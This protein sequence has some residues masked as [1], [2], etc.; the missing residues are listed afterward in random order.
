MD[1]WLEA[2]YDNRAKVPDHPSI[3]Q[4]WQRDAAA[5]RA[6]HPHLE[7]GLAYGDTPRQAM[8]LFWPDGRRDAPVALFLHGGYW[9]ALDRSWFSHLAR[10]FVGHG[11][12]LAVPSYDLCPQVTL[13][14]L[15][16]QVRDAA[17]FL[18]RRH[19]RA[20]FASGHSAGGHLAAMLLAADWTGRGLPPGAV[21]GA[22]VVSG[23]FDLAPLLA[24]RINGALGLDAGT[25]RRLSPVFLPSPGLPLRA[26]VGEAEGA[27]YRRQSASIAAAWGGAWAVLPGANHFTAIAPLADPS[28][29][30]VATIL[31]MIRAAPGSLTPKRR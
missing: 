3:M 25:A 31:G 15:V 17:A 13:G 16:E 24:T 27:E 10:G 11:V 1:P 30:L 29:P 12:A 26:V 14:T 2:E 18:V 21:H 19:G 4:G 23:L 9:Q 6:A 8:D 20:V 28:S 7:A 5:F 22:C